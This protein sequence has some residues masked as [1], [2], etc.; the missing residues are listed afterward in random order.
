MRRAAFLPLVV[1]TFFLL[2]L[3]AATSAA[4]DVPYDVEIKLD[5]LD[6]DKLLGSLKDTSQLVALRKKKVPETEAALRRRIDDDEQRLVGVMQAAGYWQATVDDKIDKDKSPA[7]V[8]VTVKPGP[9]FHLATI[10]FQLPSGA[11][12]ELVGKLG[13]EALGVKPGDPAKSAP[14]AAV[15]QRII[16]AYGHQGQPFAKIVDRHAVIDVATAT[17]NVTYTVE[18]GPSARFGKL[19]VDGL[20]S[21][22]R[23]VVDRRI[24]WHEGDIFDTR[25]VEK[26]RQSLVAS[27]LFSAVEIKHP[28]APEADGAVPLTF[29]LTEAPHHSVGAGVGYNTNYRAGVRGFWE[30]RNLLGSAEALRLSAGVAQRQIG[31]AAN[32]RRPDLEWNG[33]DFVSNVELLRQ[34]TDAYNSRRA[35]FYAGGEARMFQPYVFG[36]G[37]LVEGAKLT[38]D[39]PGR[40]EDY[41]LLGLPLYGRRDTTDNLLDPTKGSRLSLTVT[42]YHSLMNSGVGGT[43]AN[44]VSS[45]VQGS[46][47]QQLGPTDRWI[48]AGYGAL[49]SIIGTELDDVPL[50]KRLYAGGAGSVRGFG[51]QLAGPLDSY[52]K[53][54]GGRSS[55][56]FGGEVRYR[57]TETFGIVPFF[58][59]GDVYPTAL[60]ESTRLFYSAG[61]GL[62]YYTAIGPVRVD[63]AAP[64]NKR[65]TDGPVQFYVSLGQAF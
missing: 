2:A 63:V 43:G 56:E 5:G 33:F 54:T 45:R 12:A 65:A 19:I 32:F 47:Y 4:A 55:L 15:D 6:D 27:G 30:D 60:P 25:A 46:L 23:S 26:A 57:F 10:A 59:A 29:E 62:R 35:A 16:D 9:L 7:E 14:V 36:G 48:L 52:D 28:D 53:P 31:G 34:E 44:F 49:G 41:L 18:P 3:V 37:L 50:D 8:T 22:N 20:K 1:L 40:D 39:E 58:D 42:P 61:I 38:T 64:L 17:M 24:S 11:R 51:Y 21:L 13:A